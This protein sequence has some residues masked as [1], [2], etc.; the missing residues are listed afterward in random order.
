[1]TSTASRIGRFLR[2]TV[3]ARRGSSR[4]SRIGMA[5]FEAT[6]NSPPAFSAVNHRA[7]AKVGPGVRIL[8][9]PPARLSHQC[10]TWLQAQEARLRRECALGRD[11]RTG[12]AGQE[13]ARLWLAASTVN[14]AGHRRDR[15]AQAPSRAEAQ[16]PSRAEAPDPSPTAR[17]SHRNLLPHVFFSNQ[18]LL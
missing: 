4:F 18:G 13:P 7:P 3:L 15:G 14:F 11:Q 12:R 9:A 5:R 17:A 16:I 10:P 6:G 8:F 1:M 2:D